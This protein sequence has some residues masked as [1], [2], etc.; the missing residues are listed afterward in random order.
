[1][2]RLACHFV[3]QHSWFF[4][5]ALPSPFP[6]L[7]KVAFCRLREVNF[8]RSTPRC[9]SH[10]TQWSSPLMKCCIQIFACG[11]KGIRLWKQNE[12]SSFLHTHARVHT[13][14]LARVHPCEE[15]Q[16]C[17]LFKYWYFYLSGERCLEISSEY[18]CQKNSEKYVRSFINRVQPCEVSRE[19]QKYI[20]LSMKNRSNITETSA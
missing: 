13:H 19:Q 18:S 12:K 6:P 20:W 5:V 11:L 16:I 1:M 8:I 9:A 17:N 10:V 3:K 15:I 7:D 2:Y 14:T 4:I